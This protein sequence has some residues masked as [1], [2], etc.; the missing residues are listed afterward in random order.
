MDQATLATAEPEMLRL[1]NEVI[2]MILSGEGALL[3][4]ARNQWALASVQLSEAGSH[5]FY[6]NISVPPEAPR[7]PGGGF[8]EAHVETR[9]EPVW[10]ILYAFGDVLAFLEVANVIDWE[11]APQFG[12]PKVVRVFSSERAGGDL[13]HVA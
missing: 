5:G 12:P 4:A 1:A 3:D 13:G 9:G 8:G 7:L 6:L 11:V 2:P 10:C